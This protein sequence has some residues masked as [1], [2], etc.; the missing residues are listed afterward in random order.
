MGEEADLCLTLHQGGVLPSCLLGG[1]IGTRIGL[2]K[3]GQHGLDRGDIAA[4][5][6]DPAIGGSPLL[7]QHPAPLRQSAFDRAIATAVPGNHRRNEPLG[8]SRCL[9]I[10]AKRRALADHL[11]ER[12]AGNEECSGERVDLAI[13]MIARDQPVVGVPHREAVRHR[14]DGVDQQA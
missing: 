5:A 8:V 4:N 14:L 13:A 11:L 12:H 6:D 10:L 7:H 9:G 1:F 3:L 2:R